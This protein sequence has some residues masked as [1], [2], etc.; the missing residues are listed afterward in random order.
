MDKLRP[1]HIVIAPGGLRDGL[2]YRSLPQ[3]T[4]ARSA[5][6][7]ACASIAGFHSSGASMGTAMFEFLWNIHDE[8]PRTYDLESENRI[9]KA[10]CLLIST[11]T[12]LHPDHRAKI[13][14]KI[15]LYGPMPGLTHKERAY[16]ALILFRA[17]RSRK[18]PPDNAVI[19]HLLNENE[20]V[21]AQTYGEAIRAAV[22]LSGRSAS[23]L[24]KF[25]VSVSGGDLILKVHAGAKALIIERTRN[26]FID[27]AKMMGRTLCVEIAH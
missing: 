6:F 9:R 17:Y 18:T 21:S 7:D 11:G 15:A 20:Q 16:L 19:Q 8:L 23:A 14:Y 1:K 2:I 25:S 24:Q 10:A 5:L 27:L 22:V 13:V 26:H 12:G 3:A 4:K